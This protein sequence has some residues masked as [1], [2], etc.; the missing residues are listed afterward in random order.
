MGTALLL[1]HLLSRA[2]AER[3][4][5]A[6][7]APAWFEA[8]ARLVRSKLKARTGWGGLLVPWL[9][10]E[11][12]TLLV[13]VL[14]QSSGALLQ[15]LCILQML[16]AGSGQPRRQGLAA[17]ACR[18][19]LSGVGHE[20]PGGRGECVGRSGLA[21]WMA[22]TL[23]KGVWHAFHAEDLLLAWVWVDCLPQ[24]L[25]LLAEANLSAAA[26]KEQQEKE[27]RL[28]SELAAKLVGVKAEQQAMPP[29]G[30]AGADRAALQHITG[31][32]W[33]W[34]LRTYDV[35]VAAKLVVQRRSGLM[36]QRPRRHGW[37]SGRPRHQCRSGVGR[38]ATSQ[39]GSIAG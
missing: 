35:A 15:H 6:S 13:A 26:K 19:N 14:P 29:R 11:I 33:E 16:C 5:A 38:C 31:A 24:E 2:L 30:A 17:A 9:S 32:G 27:R 1:S 7:D 34:R 37:Q 3:P 4:F 25:Q 28:A 12:V 22:A 10:R 20:Q 8:T 21:A 36:Q 18:N 39:V 23:G